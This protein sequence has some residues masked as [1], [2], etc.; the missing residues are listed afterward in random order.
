MQPEAEMRYPPAARERRPQLAQLRT[1]GSSVPSVPL[2]QI[3][4]FV[5]G[6]TARRRPSEYQR[7]GAILQLDFSNSPVAHLVL[8]GVD[9]MADSNNTRIINMAKEPNTKLTELAERQV[10]KWRVSG[11]EIDGHA[12]FRSA[13]GGFLLVADVDF[14]AGGTK[15]KIIQHIAYDEG[16]DTLQSHHMDTWVMIQLTLGYWMAKKFA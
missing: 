10:G 3:T 11:P 6:A 5:P 9:D 13:K 2:A 1:V 16:T 4:Q 7:I 12:E 14:V 15:M 8:I